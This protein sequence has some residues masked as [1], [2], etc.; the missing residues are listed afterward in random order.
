MEAKKAKIYKQ[1]IEVAEKK[2]CFFIEQLVAFLP[3]VKSTFYDYFPVG[4][5]EL[6]AIKAILEKNRVEVK[7]S[8]Y[9]KWFK[10]DNPTL[11]I[12]L[13]KLIATD[14]EAHRLNGTRQQL[15][16]TSTDGS[17]SP[18]AIEV[19]VRKSDENKT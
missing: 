17:M 14:E 12:A 8:M 16:M 15:D 7:T 5:D 1:A 19:T 10:S 6:N 9:N 13:M 11:Q 3:I 4:S 18:K 2:K